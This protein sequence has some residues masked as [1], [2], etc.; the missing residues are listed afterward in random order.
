[1]TMMYTFH[2]ALRRDLDRIARVTARTDDDDP[3][4]VLRV[5]RQPA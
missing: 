4:H 3:K 2:D 5:D 1:M